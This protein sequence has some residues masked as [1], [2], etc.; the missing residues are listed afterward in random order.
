MDFSIKQI[1]SKKEILKNHK[2]KYWLSGSE[3]VNDNEWD[4][5]ILTARSEVKRG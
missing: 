1:L 4:T 2:Q 3:L 5:I